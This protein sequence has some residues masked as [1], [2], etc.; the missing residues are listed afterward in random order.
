MELRIV[1]NYSATDGTMPESVEVVIAEYDHASMGTAMLDVIGQLVDAPGK[2]RP[3]TV[4]LNPDWRP[5]P[6]DGAVS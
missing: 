2:A 1:A 4:R 5:E 6:A 3:V